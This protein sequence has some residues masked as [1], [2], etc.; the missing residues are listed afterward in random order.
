[1]EPPVISPDD[2][3]HIPGPMVV[4]PV[5]PPG[6]L[7]CP[8]CATVYAATLGRHEPGAYAVCGHCSMVVVFMPNGHPRLPTYDEIVDAETNPLIRLLQTSF[9]RP[10]PTG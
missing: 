4:D 8:Q 3:P 5:A 2:E 1:M 7:L 6:K 10:L 9:G